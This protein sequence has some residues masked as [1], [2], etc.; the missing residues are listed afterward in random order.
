MLAARLSQTIVTGDANDPG[1]GRRWSWSDQRHGN[2]AVLFPGLRNMAACN[3]TGG[4]ASLI[5]SS[6]DSTETIY[7]C[8]RLRRHRAFSGHTARR[9][10]QGCALRDRRRRLYQTTH[11]YDVTTDAYHTYVTVITPTASPDHNHP[12]EPLVRDHRWPTIGLGP[13]GCRPWASLTYVTVIS[14][15]GT[16]HTGNP[17]RACPRRDIWPSTWPGSCTSPHTDQA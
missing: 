17:M 14:P 15:D 7:Q 5:T 16:V 12:G 1:N 6:Y 4:R 8:N 13:G 3:S 11:A 9:T 10:S 2:H